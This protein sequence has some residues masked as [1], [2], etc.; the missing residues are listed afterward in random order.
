[1]VTDLRVMHVI[2]KGDV[3]GAQT[4]VVELC[5]AQLKS[6]LVPTVIAGV[7]GP[8]VEQLQSSGIDTFLIPSL[9]GSMS[10][11]LRRSTL[12]ELRSM[13]RDVQPDIVH[14]HS[15]AAGLLARAAAR[16]EGCPSVY[17]AHGWPFQAGAR[18]TQRAMSLAGESIGGRFGDAVICLTESEASLARRYRVARKDAIYVIPNG[19]ADV[20]GTQD[21]RVDHDR[22]PRVVMTARFAPPKLQH[23]L[24]RALAQI[25]DLPWNLA[26]IGDGPQLDSCRRLGAEV[27]GD[28]VEFLG[29]R[30]DVAEVLA[31]SDV[32]VLWSRYEGMPIALL[33]GMR[34]GLCCIGSDLP[35]VRTLFGT[36]PV[37]LTA[38]TLPELVGVLRRALSDRDL[39]AR[40]GHDAR[41]RFEQHFSA[42][43]MAKAT[44]EVYRQVIERRRGRRG[45]LSSFGP[46]N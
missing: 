23:E 38:S 33:E 12:L 1:M 44:L 9:T 36:P 25:I 42:D 13:I 10:E 27:L 24:I 16:R 39:R 7:G 5:R 28:R 19:L 30:N 46:N 11:L 34:A 21:R 18:A 17:T 35:G 4:H 14:G 31:L 15:S 40:F 29:H 22:A 37:G 26:L 32:L 6:G 20:P 43:V 41:S 3:G 2:T 45:H 8:A